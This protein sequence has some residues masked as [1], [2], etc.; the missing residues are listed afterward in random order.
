MTEPQVGAGSRT[1]RS[2]S[3][4]VPRETR[5]EGFRI[6]RA[7]LDNALAS[8]LMTPEDHATEIAALDTMKDGRQSKL[9]RNKPSRQHDGTTS[10]NH[11]SL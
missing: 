10:D 6:T 3:P 7:F 2:P 4:P 8:G 1:A 11:R 9:S 5:D